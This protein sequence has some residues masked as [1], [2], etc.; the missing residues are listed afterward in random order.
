MTIFYRGRHAAKADHDP[1]PADGPIR[2]FENAEVIDT[3]VTTTATSAVRGSE[4]NPNVTHPVRD[5]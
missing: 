3:S 4:H 5:R 2:L 1:A